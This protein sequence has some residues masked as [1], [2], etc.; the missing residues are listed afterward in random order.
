MATNPFFD[1]AASASRYVDFDVPTAADLN[2]PL[3]EVTAGFD[4]VDVRI[5]A[6]DADLAGLSSPVQT[7]LDGKADITGE[8]YSGAQ[9]FTGATLTAATQ[10]SSDASTK[11]ATTAFVA[12][13]AFTTAT[14]LTAAS[15]GEMEAGTEAALRAMSPLRVAQAIAA[16]ADVMVREARATNTILAAA[17]SGKLIEYTGSFTQTFNTAANLGAGW[18]VFLKNAFTD[19]VYLTPAG[20]ATIDGATDFLMYPGEARLL[21][22]DGTNFHSV[23]MKGFTHVPTTSGFFFEPPGYIGWDVYIQA[24]GGGGGSGARRA[25]GNARGG[26]GSGGGGSWAQAFIK[27]TTPGTSHTITIGAP[28]PG[29][30]A[31]AVDDTVG[32]DGTAGGDSSFG[33][34]LVAKGGGAGGGGQFGGSGAAGAAG[35][36][37]LGHLTLAGS[38]GALGGDGGG[39]PG[40]AGAA[41]TDWKATGGGGGGSLTGANAVEAAGAGGASGTTVSTSQTAGGLAGAAGGAGGVGASPTMSRRPGTGGGGG[42]ASAAAAGGAGG[43]GVRGGGGGGGAASANTYASGAGGAGGAGYFEIVGVF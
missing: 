16:L 23:L 24:P 42:A 27:A 17:D 28:G 29:G 43:A 26:G 36:A 10:A 7:Q 30:A 9:N 5:D 3:D 34:L 14:G 31:V 11:V 1:F 6:I 19:S 13:V 20:G 8:T 32:T 15:Q 35:A 33:A 2:A 40:A 39:T 41:A 21:Q 38:A 12:D 22:C 4:A 25:N 37:V 18:F